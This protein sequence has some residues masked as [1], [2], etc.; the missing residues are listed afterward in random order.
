MY[1]VSDFLGYKLGPKSDGLGENLPGGADLS[2]SFLRILKDHRN[3]PKAQVYHQ[4]AEL[5]H[6]H[7]RSV[8]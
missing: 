8:R 5:F 3:V 4:I 2:D 7:P 1:S 6:E